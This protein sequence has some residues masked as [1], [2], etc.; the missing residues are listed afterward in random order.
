VRRNDNI[1]SSVD[2]F[3]HVRSNINSSDSDSEQIRVGP[4]YFM[5]RGEYEFEIKF[6][7][8]VC[9]SCIYIYRVEIP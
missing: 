4:D 7:H 9:S 2:P 5:D 6:V 3:R 8:S 1:A